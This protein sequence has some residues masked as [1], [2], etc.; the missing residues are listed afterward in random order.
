MVGGVS[1]MLTIKFGDIDTSLGTRALG[2]EIRQKILNNIELEDKIVFD[3][4]GI[5][6]ISNSFA[7][8]C[9]GKLIEACGLEATKQKTTFAN[10][11]SDV[12]LVIKKAIRGRIQNECC[13]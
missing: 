13:A 11:N 1:K 3:F 12:A 7:D 10:A 4:Q 2:H 9:F 5:D 8:E 6:I